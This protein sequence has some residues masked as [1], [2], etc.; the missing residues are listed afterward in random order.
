MSAIEPEVTPPRL[1][2]LLDLFTALRCSRATG[3]SICKKYSVEIVKVGSKSLIPYTEIARVISELPRGLSR[4]NS[5][6]PV[7]A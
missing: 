2:P 3:Y 1:I 4:S 7:L 6:K 5:Q